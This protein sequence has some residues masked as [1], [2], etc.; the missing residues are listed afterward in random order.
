VADAARAAGK[1]AGI[2]CMAPEHIPVVRGEGFTFVMLGSD[3]S[4]AATGL[5]G[6]A[7]ALLK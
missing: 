6:F 7:A 1:A 3:A 4:A 5:R 2:L